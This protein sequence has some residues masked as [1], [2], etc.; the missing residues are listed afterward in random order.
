MTNEEA[1]EILLTIHEIYPTYEITERKMKI[2]VPALLTMDLAGVVK[3][4]N[5][6]ILTNSW[7]PTISDIAAY[8]SVENEILKKTKEYER[9]ACDHPP[10]EE[11]IQEFQARFQ[12]LVG[13]GKEDE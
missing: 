10:T 1:A 11:Q 9:L 4:L 12:Q 5:E 3:R 2:L 13:G 7:P 8:P 6:Y